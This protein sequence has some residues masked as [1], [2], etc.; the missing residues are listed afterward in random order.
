[1]AITIFTRNS[2]ELLEAFD[3]ATGSN[4]L[5][6]CGNEIDILYQALKMRNGSLKPE[7]FACNSKSG[8]RGICFNGEPIFSHADGKRYSNRH[9]WEDHLK[10]TNCF[11]VGNEYNKKDISQR[12]LRGNFN[13]RKELSQAT[14][15]V[16]NRSH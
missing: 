1:M 14:H 5:H 13:P 11:E 8:D 2:K 4:P 3:K 10:A 6:L 12:K 7:N 16:L 9:S 15:E